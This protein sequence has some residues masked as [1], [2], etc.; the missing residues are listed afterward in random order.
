MVMTP[1]ELISATTSLVAS[2]T[3]PALTPLSPETSKGI[4]P[5][6]ASRWAETVKVKRKKKSKDTAF[7]MLLSHLILKNFNKDPGKKLEPAMA[8]LNPAARCPAR[9]SAAANQ[10][11]L[12][13]PTR[14]VDKAGIYVTSS[15]TA[16][17]TARNGNT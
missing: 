9:A 16:I 10:G 15:T 1:Q 2:A 11:Y 8:L 12:N 6:V 4:I 7:F 3:S 17:R 14:S 5:T 13:K